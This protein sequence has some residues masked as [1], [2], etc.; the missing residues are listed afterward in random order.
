M[1]L[2]LALFCILWAG[3]TWGLIAAFLTLLVFFLT[4]ALMIA[5]TL[6]YMKANDI[7]HYKLDLILMEFDLRKKE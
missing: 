6:M 7:E 5:A 1:Y 3:A 4:P 2:I